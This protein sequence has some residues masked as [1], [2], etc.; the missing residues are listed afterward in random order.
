MSS[1]FSSGLHTPCECGYALHDKLEGMDETL[2]AAERDDAQLV[3][4]DSE[5]E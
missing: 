3:M 1:W 5:K 4:D 2:L